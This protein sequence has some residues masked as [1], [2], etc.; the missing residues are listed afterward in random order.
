MLPQ[1]KCQKLG[2]NSNPDSCSIC[3]LL[4]L[5]TMDPSGGILTLFFLRI[6]LWLMKA[7]IRYKED[8]KLLYNG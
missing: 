6:N 7:F 3:I 8:K 1:A 4:E 2:A 5:S